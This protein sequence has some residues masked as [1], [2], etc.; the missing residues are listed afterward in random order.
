VWFW[1]NGQPDETDRNGKNKGN[2]EMRL[3]KTMAKRGIRRRQVIREGS[4]RVI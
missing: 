3:E 4:R 1:H 2:E